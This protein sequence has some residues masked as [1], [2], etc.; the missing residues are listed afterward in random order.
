MTVAERGFVG[1]DVPSFQIDRVLVAV[2]IVDSRSNAQRLIKSGAI[3]WRK[4]DCKVWQDADGKWWKQALDWEKVTD[5]RQEL[6]PGWPW[7]LRVGN[8]HWRTV[9]VEVEVTENAPFG[10]KDQTPIKKK[11]TKPKMFN[12]L[13]LVMR[14]MLVK[15]TDENGQP[16]EHMQTKECWTEMWDE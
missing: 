8:G 9:Q 11:V 13:A 14:P 7:V 10:A 1:I 5:F 4:D 6:E 15:G 12:S 3:S 16:Y 2:G